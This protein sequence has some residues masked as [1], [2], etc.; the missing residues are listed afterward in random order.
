VDS[1]R[2]D[3]W[4]R[5]RFGIATAGAVAGLFRLGEH[6]DA[7]AKRK[8]KK[9]HKPKCEKHRTRCNPKNDKKLCCG[10]LYCDEVPEL[11]GNHCCRPR[12]GSCEQDS[13][14]CGN[15]VCTSGFCD[16]SS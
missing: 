12:Y 16:L 15:T 8:R 14:C 5:R 7:P 1:S 13:D 6:D 2:F 11:G 3:A 4:T 9:K 10:G